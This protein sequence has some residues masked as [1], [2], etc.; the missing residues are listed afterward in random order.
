MKTVIET[1]T[2]IKTSRKIWSEDEIDELIEYVSKNS[3]AG[4][5]IPHAKGLR[6]LRWGNQHS[7]K[8][9]GNRVIYINILNDKVI[10]LLAYKKAKKKTTTPSD[11]KTIL[12]ELNNDQ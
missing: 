12:N 7:G 9:G 4:E 3:N 1:P 11:L 8:R 10:L 5:V 2:F 6:K